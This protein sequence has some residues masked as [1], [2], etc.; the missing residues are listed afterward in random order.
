MKVKSARK[1]P[2]TAIVLGGIRDKPLGE[3]TDMDD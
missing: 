1:D 2:G 3:S